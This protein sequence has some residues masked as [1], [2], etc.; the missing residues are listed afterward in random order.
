MKAL[1]LA[2]EDWAT[3]ENIIREKAIPKG[4]LA[5]GY[6]EDFT[7]SHEKF[8]VQVTGASRSPCVF[9]LLAL[10]SCG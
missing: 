2:Q 4:E 8:A 9:Y 5:L 3:L 7:G 6:W 1:C 10:C